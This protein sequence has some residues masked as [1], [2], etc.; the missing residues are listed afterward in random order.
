VNDEVGVYHHGFGKIR[1]LAKAKD[2]EN[3]S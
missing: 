2:R 3:E 1:E